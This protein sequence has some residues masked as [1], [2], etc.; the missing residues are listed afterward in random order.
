MRDG[1]IAGETFAQLGTGRCQGQFA[2][3]LPDEDEAALGVG[4]LQ[5]GTDQRDQD[6]IERARG[7][8]FAGC[9]QEQRQLLQVIGLFRLDAR[10]LAQEF[11][12]DDR[13][14]IRGLEDQLRTHADAKLDAVVGR[15]LVLRHA[16]LVDEGAHLAAA[17]H[18]VI[19]AVLAE[20][21][22][23]VARDAR[24]RD[25]Q[26]LAGLAPDGEGH[27][28]HLQLFL[29]SPVDVQERGESAGSLR[30]AGRNSAGDGRG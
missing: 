17:V 11:A 12:G 5:R 4:Q 9:V 27:R 28:P 23:V 20:D 21:L 19:G 1:L 18:H 6:L 13:L 16:L 30:R 26:V 7:V 8:E 10:D 2:V 29:L 15:E 14:V 22:R 24:V 3:R 25:L